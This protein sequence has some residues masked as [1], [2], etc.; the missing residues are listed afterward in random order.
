[1]ILRKR[2]TY[3]LGSKRP[4]LDIKFEG[5]HKLVPEHFIPVPSQCQLKVILS[6]LQEALPRV[7]SMKDYSFKWTEGS[8]QRSSSVVQLV[9]QS[10]QK[11]YSEVVRKSE[12]LMTISYADILTVLLETL[13][14]VHYLTLT[15]QINVQQ[16]LTYIDPSLYY[17][18]SNFRYKG[19][20]FLI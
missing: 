16:M 5:T 6:Q 13:R 4:K 2:S 17:E 8:N 3:S 14:Q 7:F 1:M 10:I 15:E 18:Y 12:Q 20:F 19:N 11:H 9:V